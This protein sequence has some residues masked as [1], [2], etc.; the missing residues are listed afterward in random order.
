MEPNTLAQVKNSDKNR[1]IKY[2]AGSRVF[3]GYNHS[4]MLE[5][6]TIP[7]TTVHDHGIVVDGAMTCM[8]KAPDNKSQYVSGFHGDFKELDIPTLK[9]VNSIPL[10]IAGYFVVTCDNKTLITATPKD[11]SVLTQMSVRTKKI[12]QTWKSNVSVPICSQ[13]TSYDSRYQ[14]AGHENGKIEI[15][16]LQK[17]QQ[18][19]WV[20]ALNGR[21][22]K[23]WFFLN[24]KNYKNNNKLPK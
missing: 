23:R 13:S 9:Q 6:L 4:S 10:K 15:F 5:L 14:L 21:I 3:V 18:F 22:Q 8:A 1:E 19:K 12:L 7:K 20:Q 2:P 24:K 16:D 17:Q 11:Q